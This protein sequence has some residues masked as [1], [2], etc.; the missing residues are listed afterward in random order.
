MNRPTYSI[1]IPVHNEAENLSGPFSSFIE[2]MNTKGGDVFGGLDNVEII[3]AEDGSTDGTQ[4]LLRCIAPKF[5]CKV[6]VLNCEKR[7]GKGGGF[8]NGF[9]HS[10]NDIVI[11]YDADISVSP[12]QLENLA[13]KMDEGYDIVIGSRNAP[14]S[15]FLSFP[16]FTRF[17][18]GKVLYILAKLLFFIPFKETQCGF[19]AF[20]RRRV[21]P[22]MHQ[23]V[24]SG[25][26]FDLELLLRAYYNNYN[27]KE[28]P[29]VYRFFKVSKIRNIKDPVQVFFDL[30]RLRARILHYYLILPEWGRKFL[31]KISRFK[32]RPREKPTQKN[33]R[34]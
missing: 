2:W 31:K 20:R 7:L 12:G 26:L 15:R 4:V 27:I 5:L 30:I 16:Q 1:V 9:L 19:K 11:L 14:G 28:I 10:R 29:V 21:A 22:I 13:R 34:N 32:S 8:K 3:F 33:S 18:Y 6:Q 23:L 24:L 17:V 25:W